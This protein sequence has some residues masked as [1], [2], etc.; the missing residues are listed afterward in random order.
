MHAI[1]FRFFL[2]R[3]VNEAENI[4]LQF[5]LPN[6]QYFWGYGYG[7]KRHFQQYLNYI[8]AVSF[9]DGENWSTQRKPPTNLPQATGKLYHI[10]LY[11]VLLA[12]S[13]S[14]DSHWLLQLP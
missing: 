14:G 7:N 12:M 10:I 5:R 6:F 13:F 2:F 8:V 1:N 11:G 4:P 3:F 9:I